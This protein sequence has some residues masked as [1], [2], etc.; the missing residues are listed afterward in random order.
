MICWD[1]YSACPGLEGVDVFIDELGVPGKILCASAVG[2]R[3]VEVTITVKTD[4]GQSRYVLRRHMGRIKRWAR[5]YHEK[6]TL[7]W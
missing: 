1:R 2:L 4:R 3:E 5:L 6:K 7:G